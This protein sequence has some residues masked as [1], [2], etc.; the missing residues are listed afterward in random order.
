MLQVKE[1]HITDY[2]LAYALLARSYCNKVLAR[3]GTLSQISPS[4]GGIFTLDQVLT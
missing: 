4:R 3:R 1:P 2:T